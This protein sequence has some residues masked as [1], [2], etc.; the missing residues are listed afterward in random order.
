MSSVRIRDKTCVSVRAY[1]TARSLTD[2]I[3][4]LYDK[5]NEKDEKPVDVTAHVLSP[6]V[7]IR[8]NWSW[9]NSGQAMYWIK[10][11]KI[12]RRLCYQFN[13]RPDWPEL[14]ILKFPGSPLQD[15]Q[16]WLDKH[17]L[18]AHFL[19]VSVFQIWNFIVCLFVTSLHVFSQIIQVFATNLRDH[20]R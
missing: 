10:S 5:P 1:L 12:S 9:Q 20:F 18:L 6:T 4:M 7:R 11:T 14:A 19:E 13:Q 15:T 2:Q 3:K 16:S 17:L 8:N